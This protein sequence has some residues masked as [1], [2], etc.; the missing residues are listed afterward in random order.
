MILAPPCLCL[1]LPLL[2]FPC[3]SVPLPALHGLTLLIR[4]LPC[5][6]LTSHSSPCLVPS[7]LPLTSL[8]YKLIHTLR[9]LP[10]T[11]GVPKPIPTPYTIATTL[12]LTLGFTEL[13]IR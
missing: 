2:A 5:H 9:R 10:L 1:P 8:P 7:S 11:P 13:P 3:S 12:A 6:S 4:V